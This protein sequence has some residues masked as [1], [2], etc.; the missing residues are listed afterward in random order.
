MFITTIPTTEIEAIAEALADDYLSQWPVIKAA[1]A[2]ALEIP[3]AQLQDA[4]DSHPQHILNLAYNH[5]KRGGH[6][7][8]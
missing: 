2:A 6:I 8:Y 1:L 3:E 7:S 4:L 5:L